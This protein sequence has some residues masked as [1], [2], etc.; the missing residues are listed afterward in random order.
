MAVAG[1]RDLRG[2][3]LKQR[4]Y[5]LLECADLDAALEALQALS[6]RRVVNPLFSLLFNTNDQIRWRA[7]TAMGV[8]ASRLADEDME[9]ARVIMRRLMW[10]LNDESGGIGWG[11]AEAMG[12]ILACH[13]G[14][15]WEYASILISYI[16][17][18][19][20]FQEYALMQ[21]GVLWGIARLAG[22]R[23]ELAM[24]AAGPVMP[25]LKSG[26]ANAK[27]LA[28]RIMGFLMVKEARSLLVELLE[29]ESAFT[30][31]SDRAVVEWTVKEAASEALLAI[32]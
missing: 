27:G 1:D 4:V 29:D 7:I 21:R 6:P 22:E 15:A 32:H 14:L 28:A 9:S 23:P 12:E 5:D 30:L 8:V 20:N 16:R 18:D 17:E 24:G 11:S 13:K 3:R 10:N 19:G 26:D 25:F 2:R 31:Y